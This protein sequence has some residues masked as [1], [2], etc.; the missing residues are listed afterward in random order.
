[1]VALLCVCRRLRTHSCFAQSERS[2]G[3]GWAKSRNWCGKVCFCPRI[4]RTLLD[5]CTTPRTRFQLR[6]GL[7]FEKLLISK[8]VVGLQ[9]RSS[10]LCKNW[11]R[12]RAIVLDSTNYP[13]HKILNECRCC[14]IEKEFQCGECGVSNFTS[15]IVLIKE[16]VPLFWMAL[17]CSVNRL[18]IFGGKRALFYSGPHKMTAATSPP[19]H[20]NSRFNFI[21][22]RALGLGTKR[23]FSSPWYNVLRVVGQN[24]DN[25]TA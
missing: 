23:L 16:L 22:S 21:L 15:Q 20:A 13:W 14:H 9:T 3:F 17:D 2:G 18:E 19:T 11:A 6:F 12:L 4:R 7:F 25:P 10:D 24:F 1:M 5:V 8:I